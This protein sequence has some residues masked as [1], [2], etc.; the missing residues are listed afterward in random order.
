[1]KSLIKKLI[2]AALCLSAQLAWGAIKVSNV[3]V[4]EVGETQ[5]T[6]S[7]T[8]DKIGNSTVFYGASTWNEGPKVVDAAFV[9]SHRLVVKNL[10]PNTSYEFRVRSS[11]NGEE[12]LSSPARF[13]TKAPPAP[14]H[15]V[16][17]WA[18]PA[19]VTFPTNS[20]MLRSEVAGADPQNLLYNWELAFGPP[21]A[22]ID[23]IHNPATKAWFSTTGQFR[24]RLTVKDQST[25]KSASAETTVT[26]HAAPT[27]ALTVN[28]GAGDGLY[29][30]GFPVNVAAEN[31]PPGKIFSAWTG[32]VAHLADAASPA[33]I[34]SMPAGP[35]TI[36]ATYKDIPPPPVFP[37]TV[38]GG[39]GGGLYGAGARIPIVANPPPEGQVF[40]RWSGAP[41][42][43]FDNVKSP[44][45]VFTMPA[46]GVVITALYRPITRGFLLEVTNGTGDGDY[47]AG[48]VVAI[49][50]VPPDAPD[51]QFLG[52]SG[53]TATIADVNSRFTTLVMPAADIKVGAVFVPV[54]PHP[55][56][57]LT[58]N[59]GTG[60]G[61]YR[62]GMKV[63]IHAFP[64]GENQRFVRWIGSTKTVVDAF[65]PDTTLT[66]PEQD[67]A[68]TA[69]F[70]PSNIFNL[71]VSNGLG[72]GQYETGAVVT[73][74]AV[75]PDAPNQLF[76]GW[77]G[78][79]A[80]V[81]NVNSPITTLVMPAADIKVSAR[82]LPVKPNPRPVISMVRQG[83]VAQSLEHRISL[84]ISGNPEV[85]QVDAAPLGS[86]EVAGG[87][88]ALAAYDLAVPG[89]SGYVFN[90]PITLTLP[91]PDGAG[92]SEA[93]LK[94]YAY[95]AGQWKI[96]GGVVNAQDKT[97]TARVSH[98]ST[99]AIAPAQAADLAG[100]K[101]PQKFLSPALADHVN[102]WASFGPQAQEVTI[103]DATGRRVYQAS[104]DAQSGSTIQWTG[105]DEQGRFVP[106]GAYIARIQQKDG[107][108]VYQTLIVVK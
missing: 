6:V 43:G 10:K 44:A 9:K 13:N 45:T 30:Q 36:T 16:R 27:Y 24:F 102:D 21:Y 69:Q 56:Y 61:K 93:D 50:A 12:G 2:P 26:V 73:I 31:A 81:A 32:D 49:Q 53:A 15:S 65:S 17:V 38:Q 75:P 33:T 100:S 70:A 52:W 101:A 83:N 46:S 85:Q 82:Y 94:I 58:V 66:M 37:L 86:E 20:V 28:N 104:A 88:P 64:P 87:L 78:A 18:D 22:S 57:S 92:V 63:S 96:V 54:K 11:R 34:L 51:Q 23:V 67:I 105:R 55:E 99:F 41:D 3:Q 47:P 48:A 68:V 19:A 72:S 95:D 7:W 71:N 60:A 42:S 79:T 108:Q 59:N 89:H 14:A 4:V 106:S 98:F 84:V 40:D 5:A 91:Y 8:T 80:T 77:V 25:G 97:V 29:P 107:S 103:L 35:V 74:Q 76:L 62:G 1:M 90:K 39:S